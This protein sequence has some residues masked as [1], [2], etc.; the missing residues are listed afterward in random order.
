MNKPLLYQC[1]V[2]DN[3]D[4]L[5]LGRVRARLLTDNYEDII[6]SIVSP[7]WDEAVDSWGERDPFIFIP[8]LPYYVSQVPK[9]N[10]LIQILYF[11][12][13]FKYQN[14]YYVQGP[15]STPTASSFEY[16]AGAQKL[17]GIGGQYKSSLPIKNKDGSYTNQAI[18]GVFPEPGD[19][20]LLG[21]GSADVI[22]KE[23]E[24]LLRAGKIVGPLEPN[25]FP[26]GS[27]RR[28][29]VQLSRFDLNKTF[30]GTQEQRSL[31]ERIVMTNFLIEW[32]I[33]NPENT[34]DRFTGNVYLY[35]LRA[36]QRV[37][38]GNIKPE[39]QIDDLKS[40]I[41]SEPFTAL[42]LQDT[43]SFI[44]NFI[45][46]CNNE[47]KIKGIKVFGDDYKFPIYYRP[48]LAMTKLLVD[49]PTSGNTVAAT[50]SLNVKKI[51]Q[52]IKLNATAPQSGYGL[53]YA[54]DKVGV[55]FN[56]KKTLINL[57][58]Y[59][60]RPVTYGAL[61]A[62]KVFLLSHF[63]QI[64]NKKKIDF[65]GTLY[66]IDNDKFT[67]DIIPNTSS[68]VRGEELLEL[69][70]L[71]VRFLITHTHAFP[72]LPPVPVTQDGST[73]PNLLAEL[74]LANI[75]VLNENIRLN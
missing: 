31:E 70:N 53:I 40:L 36:D 51:N 28:A 3:Q 30:Q 63:S 38:S 7:P 17:T 34:Q 50:S 44:N 68:M 45:R 72:G 49:L 54:K 71:I 15:F 29:F 5:M 62:D 27:N 66:G 52:N 19:N 55:P 58:Q 64:P 2:L 26:S 4:P 9:I 24:L 25:R 65:D 37:N 33:T 56:I 20:A 8:L 11:N 67:D 61:G 21:R 12:N 22:V 32:V 35:R 14:Q 18:K 60:A 16:Y 47:N 43:V 1:V 46:L 41:V 48:T 74:G 39:S 13:E 42:S 10:E 59:N 57:F 69:L 23:N 73:V 75:K 6:S